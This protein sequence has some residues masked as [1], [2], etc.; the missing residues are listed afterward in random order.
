MAE[1]ATADLIKYQAIITQKH[2]AGELRFR[3]PDVFNSLR[4]STEIMIPSHNQIKNAAKRTTGEINF[5]D[6]TTRALGTGG[7]IHNHAGAKGDS[8]ILVP[9]WTAY[10]DKFYYSLKQ[11]NS[12]VFSF[13]QEIMS[14]MTNLFT[15]F[16]EG[17]ESAAASYIHANRSGVN[18]YTRQGTFNGTNDA[19][20]ITVATASVLDTGYR[21]VQIIKSTMQANKWSQNGLVAYCDTIMYDKLEALANQGNS[22]STNSGFQFS[23]VE[24]IKSVELD[25]LAVALDATYVNGYCVVAEMGTLS[26]LDW[27]PVQN[28][29]GVTTSV[30]KYGTLIDPN[31]GLSLATHSFEARADESGSGGE[32]QDVKVENQAFTYVSFNHSPLTTATETPLQAF[33]LK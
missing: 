22:N 31:T 8:S 32:P 7:E 33:A 10:D 21:I 15:N 26:V 14:E 24:F 6:R 12:S 28:R 4:R 20:E 29:M 17:L 5:F 3:T 16:A 18:T 11:A 9:S 13:D 30:N 1:F 2:Q 23:G 19:F 27:I 25:A